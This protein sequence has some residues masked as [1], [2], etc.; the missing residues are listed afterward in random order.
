MDWELE[1][2]A[3]ETLEAVDAPLPIDP[4]WIAY[5]LGLTVMDGGPGCEGL[6]L[7][8]LGQ[9]LVD[10]SL[11]RERRAF[12][13]AH[14]LGHFLLRRAGR[15]DR[16]RDANYLASALLLPRDDFERH[17]RR[18][19]WHLERLR[20]VHPLASFEALARRVVALRKARAFVFDK[21]LADPAKRR[22]YSVPSGARPS[23][24]EWEAAKSAAESGGPVLPYPGLSAWPVLERDWHR[25]ITLADLE[26]HRFD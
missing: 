7:D 16:E 4:D 17:L 5:R 25:V 19:G 21:S 23:R 22:W 20:G 10:D 13:I 6:L 18:Y 2:L 1:Q 14:E 26:A 12:A 24:A 3:R 8:E 11:R 15:P 9:I